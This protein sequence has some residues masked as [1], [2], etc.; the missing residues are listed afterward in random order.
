MGNRPARCPACGSEAI[1]AVE[2]VVEL[3]IEQAL[4]ERAAAEL[5]RSAAARQ[6]MTGPGP[7]AAL[8]RW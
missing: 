1:A 6:L 5:V 8:L 7:M 4:E 2:D 3:A